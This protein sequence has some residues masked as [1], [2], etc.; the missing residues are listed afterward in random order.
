M[1]KIQFEN[2]QTVE[3]DGIPSQTD[4]EEVANQLGLNKS[5]EP[6]TLA[7]KV[8]KGVKDYLPAL[9]PSDFGNRVIDFPMALENSRPIKDLE[10]LGRRVEIPI[11]NI[12]GRMA[13]NQ[14][15]ISATMLSMNAG[16]LKP[17]SMK[18]GVGLAGMSAL[19]PLAI[20]TSV[21][22]PISAP[23]TRPFADKGIELATKNI[24]KEGSNDLSTGQRISD[25]YEKNIANLKKTE[26]EAYKPLDESKK[27]ESAPANLENTRI[28][29]ENLFKTNEPG[30]IGLEGMPLDLIRKQYPSYV[31]PPTPETLNNMRE[32]QPTMPAG[33]LGIF[34]RILRASSKDNLSAS[35]VKSLRTLVGSEIDK[36]GGWNATRTNEPVFR[37]KQIYETL[38][39]DYLKSAQDS[40]IG[41][42]V[43]KASQSTKDLYSYLNKPSSKIIDRNVYPEDLP[44]KLLKTDSP[45][46]VRELFNEHNL[47]ESDKVNLRGSI[48]NKIIDKAKTE[49]PVGSQL[50]I[51]DLSREFGKLDDGFI[52]EM[53]GKDAKLVKG[54]KDAS[55]TF[56]ESFK[57]AEGGRSAPW[58][59]YYLSYARRLFS[60]YRVSPNVYQMLER[61]QGENI[62]NKIVPNAKINFPSL[63]NY[64]KNPIINP[65]FNRLPI[66][67]SIQRDQNQ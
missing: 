21:N 17:S 42:E 49:T 50:S 41:D 14:M 61:T 40:G 48:I 32:V 57:K 24:S 64:N 7:G 26:T 65:V 9:T 33:N 46:R 1:A 59:F 39:K 2:G 56:D 11:E 63:G 5:Q 6:D 30:S 43:I 12:S 20:P 66:P 13:E 67:V 47:T 4:I 35:D 45:S 38:S 8:L 16:A 51:D 52:N 25:V 29:L 15:P 55:R 31:P 27:L 19:L 58:P 60:K 3:F 54:L 44:D 36:N 53:F 18:Q 37:L 34:S 22:K 28:Y 10:S 62:A 23:F